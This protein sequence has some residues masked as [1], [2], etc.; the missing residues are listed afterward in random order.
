MTKQIAERLRFA[1]KHTMNGDGPIRAFI[2]AKDLEA[3]AARIEQLESA[4]RVSYGQVQFYRKERTKA[5]DGDFVR[6]LAEAALNGDPEPGDDWR[7]QLSTP[8]DAASG[9]GRGET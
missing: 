3:A 6:V 9:T 7:Q 4:L 1:A 2:H 8:E 5:W